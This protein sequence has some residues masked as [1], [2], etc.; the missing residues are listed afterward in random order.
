MPEAGPIDSELTAAIER[1]AATAEAAARIGHPAIRP[2]LRVEAHSGL[3]VLPRTEGATLRSMIRPPGMLESVSRARG[4]IAFLL[5][6]LAAAHGR[7]LVHG[8]LLPSQINCDAVGRPLLGPFGAHHL[9]GLAATHTGGLE[10]IIATTAPELRRAGQAPTA[11]SDRYAAGALLR[12][13][14]VGRLTATAEEASGTPELDLAT[15]LMHPDPEQR[16]LLAEALKTLRRP[17]AD[18]RDLERQAPSDSIT[19]RIL[20][21]AAERTLE[22]GIKVT[23]SETWS[24]DA[25]D[26]LCRSPSPWMQ[27]VLDRSERTL[28]LAP[29]PV[30]SRSMPSDAGSRWRDS[31][32]AASARVRGPGARRGDRRPFAPAVARENAVGRLDARARRPPPALICAFARVGPPRRV[33]EDLPCAQ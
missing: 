11:Q 2:I 32:A 14:L 13:L 21:D 28:V 22:A 1:F 17:I 25:L 30:G 10:E 16:P 8:W 6:G 19:G 15:E 5:E 12:A 27:P 4:L 24:D 18:I 31:A 33:P 7:G 23:T 20:R 29:W 26:A 9:S 3:L